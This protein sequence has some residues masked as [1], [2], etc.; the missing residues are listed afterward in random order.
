MI[1]K[2]Q[3]LLSILCRGFRSDESDWRQCQ[4]NY[5]SNILTALMKKLKRERAAGVLNK[6]DLKV[7]CNCL[8]VS[9][10]N[11]CVAPLFFELVPTTSVPRTR[12][13]HTDTDTDAKSDGDNDENDDEK[14][15]PF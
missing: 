14:A 11:S 15:P 5:R 9:V 6:V 8:L 1:S 7:P 2:A 4:A 10:V 13:Y 3:R 12:I